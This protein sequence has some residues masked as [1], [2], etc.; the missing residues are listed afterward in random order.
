MTIS[1]NNLDIKP[2]IGKSNLD[3]KSRQDETS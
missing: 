1:I 2:K 3:I